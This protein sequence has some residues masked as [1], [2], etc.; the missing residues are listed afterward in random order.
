MNSKLVYISTALLFSA[1][2]FST[3]GAQGLEGINAYINAN[4]ELRTQGNATSTA[5]KA[6]NRGNAT[7]SEVRNDNQTATTTAN[8]QGQ[9]ESSEHRSV[10]AT[11]VRTL[12]AVAERERDIGGE[13]RLIAQAQNDSAS[14]TES[15]MSKVDKKG[16]VNI[17][18]FGSDYKNL[19]VVKSEMAT[20]NNNISRLK[21]LLA[22]TTSAE[23]RVELDAQI[24][25][26]K[27]EQTKVDLYVTEHENTFSLFGWFIKLF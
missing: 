13:V 7:S 17:F 9:F 6:E 24:Q 10:V 27:S 22:K 3:A 11:F 8:T 25:A 4:T 21:A 26:L 18:F 12:L 2:V 14:T 1:A 20:T 23:D 19:G 5:A 16:S 15:A